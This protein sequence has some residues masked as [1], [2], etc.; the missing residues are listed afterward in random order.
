MIKTDSKDWRRG[1]SKHCFITEAGTKWLINTSIFD[2]LKAFSTILAELKKPENRNIY[3][4][5]RHERYSQ[6]HALVLAHFRECAQKGVHP[7]RALDSLS[8]W[9]Y[10]KRF[11]ITDMDGLLREALRKLFAVMM[12]LWSDSEDFETIENKINECYVIF[13]P[14]ML[15]WYLHLPNSRPALDFQFQEI[16]R[17]YWAEERRR[18]GEPF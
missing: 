7:F 16:E 12:Y 3:Q 8:E 17:E 14:G 11:K 15:P 1:K 13:A 18:R 6:T 10:N 4:K 9:E 5:A 2:S